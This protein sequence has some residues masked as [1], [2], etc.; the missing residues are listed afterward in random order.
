MREWISVPR[1]HT[2]DEDPARAC[3]NEP[4]HVGDYT[5]GCYRARRDNPPTFRHKSMKQPYY[6]RMRK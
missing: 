5:G 3:G 2:V 4:R 6:G 1:S